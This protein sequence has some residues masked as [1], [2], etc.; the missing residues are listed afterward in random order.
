MFP[1]GLPN[2][3]AVAQ[4]FGTVVS[5][6]GSECGFLRITLHYWTTYIL[7][8]RKHATGAAQAH[9][10]SASVSPLMITNRRWCAT[11]LSGN[12]QPMVVARQPRAV[13]SCRQPPGP[14]WCPLQG[15]ATL[16]AL[17]R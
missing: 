4:W 10:T 12:H 2:A 6:T 9:A 11:H 8:F 15:T 1:E 13:H 3:T 17:K 7:H 16:L 14:P 5:G